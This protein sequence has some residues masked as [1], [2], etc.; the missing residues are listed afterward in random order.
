MKI[1]LGTLRRMLSEVAISASVFK[2]N[3]AVRDPMDKQTVA[4]A[5]QDLE[6]SFKRALEM[7]LVLA[8]ANSYNEQTNE[9]DDAAY[10]KVKQ[11]TSAAAELLMAKVNDALEAGWVKAHQETKGADASKQKQPQTGAGAPS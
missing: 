1:R 3:K 7:N 4:K 8:M 5:A 9:F 11:A 2:N 10:E 6:N